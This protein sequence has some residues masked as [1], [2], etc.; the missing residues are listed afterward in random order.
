MSGQ[1]STRRSSEQDA[2]E[3]SEDDSLLRGMTEEERERAMARAASWRPP[4][5]HR[6]LCG[7][8]IQRT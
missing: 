8:Q 6:V 3:K 2:R 5:D 1:A 7:Q 4:H